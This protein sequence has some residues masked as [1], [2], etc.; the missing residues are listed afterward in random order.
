[1]KPSPKSVY[2]WTEIEQ[3]IGRKYQVDLKPVWDRIY[4]DFDGGKFR[5][6]LHWYYETDE[7][8]QADS[9]KTKDIQHLLKLIFDEFGWD[10]DLVC[11][12]DC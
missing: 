4:Q 1:M 2:D 3:H 5:I 12:L 8:K 9:E 10:D 7:E 6:W 11:E